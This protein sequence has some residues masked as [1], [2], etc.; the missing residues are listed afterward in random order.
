MGREIIAAWGCRR[1]LLAWGVGGVLVQRV[2]Y[3]R[4]QSGRKER[5][6]N[7]RDDCLFQASF[8]FV[9]QISPVFRRTPV[10]KQHLRTGVGHTNRRVGRQGHKK[11]GIVL[12]AAFTDVV[13]AR[14]PAPLVGVGSRFEERARLNNGC[15][16]TVSRPEKKWAITLLFFL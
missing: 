8:G 15:F 4:S 5:E 11:T 7:R 9:P 3:G 14:A 10:S 13:S 12:H 1:D 6:T 16:S 2:R